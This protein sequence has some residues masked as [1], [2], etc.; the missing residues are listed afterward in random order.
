MYIYIAQQQQQAAAEAEAAAAAARVI[1]DISQYCSKI[2]FSSFP[3]VLL[4]GPL[5]TPCKTVG[6]SQQKE[7]SH[8][9][10]LFRCS[11]IISLVAGERG[12]ICG[13]SANK[14]EGAR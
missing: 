2:R 4:T 8:N 14:K 3:F 11:F 10:Y 13:G 6:L 7:Y 5:L 1:S 12:S 9:N